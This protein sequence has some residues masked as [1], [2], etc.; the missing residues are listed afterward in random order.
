[1]GKRIDGAMA[2]WA[3]AQGYSDGR[4]GRVQPDRAASPGP[5]RWGA[6]LGIGERMTENRNKK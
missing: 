1:M 5:Y 3:E 6:A 2:K 4:K